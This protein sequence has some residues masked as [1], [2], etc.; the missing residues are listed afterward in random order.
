MKV[1]LLLMLVALLLL[2]SPIFAQTGQGGRATN[3]VAITSGFSMAIASGVC[4]LAQ[5]KA[6]AAAV[7]G[8][9]RNPAAAGAIRFALMLGLVLIESLA[10][11]TLVI[12]FV[13]GLCSIRRGPGT[14]R[15]LA[16][17]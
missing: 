10:L 1:K 9:A 11:Y 6:V 2:A 17:L 15:P 8:M 5:G 12:I 16:A 4:G 13:N 3:W 14:L 7:E